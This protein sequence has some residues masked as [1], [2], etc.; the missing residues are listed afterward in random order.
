VADDK[1]VG[2]AE[3]VEAGVEVA[4]DVQGG[5]VVEGR[6]GVGAAAAADDGLDDM[7]AGVGETVTE[8]ADKAENAAND[9]SDIVSSFGKVA[10]DEAKVIAENM[11]EGVGEKSGEAWDKTYE[12]KE[13]GKKK[14]ES[15]KGTGV[16]DL[17]SAESDITKKIDLDVLR[18]DECPE[19]SDQV[20]SADEEVGDAL[21]DT[22]GSASS[23]M[24][25]KANEVGEPE[26]EVEGF[27]PIPVVA[28]FRKIVEGRVV[29]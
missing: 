1:G 5:V 23:A 13:A 19:T 6:R 7:V 11:K 28:S 4:D 25:E 15:T 27:V 20:K 9:A 3:G 16:K 2:L 26:G 14:A 21:R 8:V 17:G 29:K 24:K 22:V 10:R 12:L 18:T